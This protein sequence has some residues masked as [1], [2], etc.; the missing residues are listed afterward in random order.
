MYSGSL[1]L[2]C[3]LL[4]RGCHIEGNRQY[5]AK[6]HESRYRDHP[7]WLYGICPGTQRELEQPFKQKVTDLYDEWLATEGL[8]RETP[9][10]NLKAPPRKAVVQWILTAWQ[11]LPE[12]LIIKSFRVHHMTM[13]LSK[14]MPEFRLLDSGSEGEDDEELTLLD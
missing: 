14:L 4:V 6:R 13:I 12:E 2:K 11:L 5:L 8:E 7:R 9:A 1:P 3:C 10:D